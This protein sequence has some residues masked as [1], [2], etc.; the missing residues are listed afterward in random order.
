MPHTLIHPPDVV[1]RAENEGTAMPTPNL[2]V[3][4]LLVDIDTWAL[5]DS[6][7]ITRREN[8]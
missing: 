3:D 1:C 6:L 4:E 8:R 7:G 2:K 5:A